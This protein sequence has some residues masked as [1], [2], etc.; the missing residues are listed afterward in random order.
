MMQDD[1]INM[2][3]R[4]EKLKRPI[5]INYNSDDEAGGP[6]GGGG[7]EG[8]GD[9]GTPPRPR[10]RRCRDDRFDELAKRLYRLCAPAYPPK[11]PKP[12]P[13]GIDMHDVLTKRLNKLRYGEIPPSL[14]EKAPEKRLA[15]RNMELAQLPKGAVKARKSDYF[16]QF[17][18]TRLLQLLI[19]MIIGHLLLLCLLIIIL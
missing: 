19:E 2:E 15:E 7:G 3:N 18:Q 9:H 4:L 12:D 8:G 6:E 13:R 5:N 11:Q 10:T 14:E 17:C 1:I 16:N